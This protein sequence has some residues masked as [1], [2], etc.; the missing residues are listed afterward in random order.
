MFPVTRSFVLFSFKVLY[1]HHYLYLSMHMN[2]SMLY[3]IISLIFLFVTLFF[4]PTWFTYSVSLVFFSWDHLDILV[5]EAWWLIPWL[6]SSWQPFMKMIIWSWMI[7][8]PHFQELTRNIESRILREIYVGII[9]A[10]LT[11]FWNVIM[12]EANLIKD[13]Y[14]GINIDV[15]LNYFW[16]HSCWREFELADVSGEMYTEND[17]CQQCS[18]LC[19]RWI[20]LPIQVV[21]TLCSLSVPLYFLEANC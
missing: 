16:K 10:E 5:L 18:W 19:H 11:F 20:D 4:V 3:V 15:K 13:I 7:F 12:V 21:N 2:W 9:Y 17:T 1:L 6:L 8:F 14:M